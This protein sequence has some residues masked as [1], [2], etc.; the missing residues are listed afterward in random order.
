[1]KQLQKIQFVAACVISFL[2][3]SIT[4][5]AQNNKTISKFYLQS[6]AGGGSHEG[7]FGELGLQAI[8]KNKWSATLSYQ[9]IEM[10]HKNI[11]ADY[12]PG[13][14]TYFSQEKSYFI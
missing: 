1:M 6:G 4:V 9:V 11:P 8:I 13:S 3:F 14:G 7:S 2:V 12:K 10:K 5:T